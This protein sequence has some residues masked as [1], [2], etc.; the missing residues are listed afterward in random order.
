MEPQ[1][2]QREGE[3]TPQDVTPD[4]ETGSPAAAPDEGERSATDAERRAD[5]ENRRAEAYLAL[6]QRERADFTNYRRRMEQERADQIRAATESLILSLLPALDDLE[7]ALN[8]VPPEQANDPLV[9]GIRLIDRSLR[10]ALERAGLQRIN[11]EGQPFDP[12]VH[13]ALMRDEAP[14]RPE[15]EV[16]REMRPG[17]R[18]G[19]RVIRPTQVSV[20][21]GA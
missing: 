3:A 18:L 17:Y 15:G 16:V 6:L 4:A 11:A 8:S 19:E 1:R 21:Q 10:A 2:D 13:E 9:Q 14:D 12:Q 20:A 5:E 7:R